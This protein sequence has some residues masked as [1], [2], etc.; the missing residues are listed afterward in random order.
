MGKFS[1]G[2]FV[3]DG[4]GDKAEIIGKD[5]KYR[6]VRYKDGDR[7]ELHK[8][9][10]RPAETEEACPKKGKSDYS[11]TSWVP[12]VGDRVRVTTDNNVF[13][14]GT[15]AGCKGVI[16]SIDGGVVG[17][18]LHHPRAGVISQAC[19]EYRKF[20]EPI[21][22]PITITAGKSYRTRYGRKVGPMERRDYYFASDNGNHYSAGG[23]CGYQGDVSGKRPGWR[24][25]RDLVA[26]WIE[27]EK[28]AVEE[29]RKTPEPWGSKELVTHA[30][31]FKVGDRVVIARNSRGHEWLEKY[32]GDECIIKAADSGGWS[33]GNGYWWPE[34]DLDL[35]TSSPPIGSTVTFVATGRLSAINENGH[36][37]VTFPGLAPAQNSFALPAQYIALAN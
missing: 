28:V 31:K 9:W 5:G 24:V 17:L 30:P 13:C 2:K 4:D 1:I 7:V 19:T 11:D 15:P 34:S 25:A 36:Y 21:T 33:V 6:V 3:F 12:K 29:A 35:L 32:V 10:L 22:A 14:P 8:K 37:Q 18:D 16:T 27:P 23:L 20:L 26:E